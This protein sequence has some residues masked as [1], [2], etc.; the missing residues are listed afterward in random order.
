M[1]RLNHYTKYKVL[2]ID[3]MGFLPIN[4][5]GANYITQEQ[6]QF[7]MKNLGLVVTAIYF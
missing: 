6:H 4:S 7:I 1:S 5:E 2:I 3:E